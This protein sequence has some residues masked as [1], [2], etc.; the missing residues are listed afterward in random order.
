MRRRYCNFIQ[1]EKV[2]YLQSSFRFSF[3]HG[4]PSLCKLR[5]LYMPFF[6][7]GNCF[8]FFY[9]SFSLCDPLTL[10]PFFLRVRKFLS[11]SAYMYT[12]LH[13]VDKILVFCSKCP[14]F[15]RFVSDPSFYC[16]FSLLRLSLLLECWIGWS[17]YF[18][19]S[20]RSYFFM[21]WTI[22]S[23]LRSFGR[24][25]HNLWP[26]LPCSRFYFEEFFENSG[27]SNPSMFEHSSFITSFSFENETKK[28]WISFIENLSA[29]HFFLILFP[30][31]LFLY[32]LLYPSTRPKCDE[33][34][35]DGTIWLDITCE[36][37]YFFNWSVKASISS[38]I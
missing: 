20:V 13:S 2:F 28:N 31:A 10:F 38:F 26:V 32:P 7:E 11:F 29:F 4:S 36:I 21:F 37:S 34:Y 6:S 17:A 14:W 16:T 25:S 35:F 23:N 8:I 24:I 27:W 19:T 18:V 15:D 33:L 3:P 22:I 12:V 9:S 1:R 30:P 5:V